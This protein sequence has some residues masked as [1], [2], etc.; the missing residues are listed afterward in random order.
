MNRGTLLIPH[1]ERSRGFSILEVLIVLV[2]LG[3]MMLAWDLAM[4]PGASERLDAGQK[5]LAARMRE[6]RQVAVMRLSHARLL[7]HA[8]PLQ[9]DLCR[10]ALA[11]AVETEPGS[12]QWEVVGRPEPL[13]RG[14]VW[15]SGAG[16]G[17][18]VA[19][20]QAAG[21]WRSGVSC[22]AFE[23]TPTGRAL[24]ARYD[25]VIGLGSVTPEGQAQLSNTKF[26]RGLWVNAYG[27]VSELPAG[28]SVK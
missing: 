19:L 17:R 24:N 26:T 10:Q 25:C 8:D 18:V 14:V 11:I 16:G 4:Q 23:F 20:V 15:A 21:A 6:A 12:G 5:L 22:I 13:P 7:V 27:L 3:M 2:I 28:Q 1:G 9:P